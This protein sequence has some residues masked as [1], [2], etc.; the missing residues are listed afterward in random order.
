MPGGFKTFARR[1]VFAAN[2]AIAIAFL[3]ACVAPY[4]NPV[5][6]WFVS[7]L[8]LLF[9]LLFIVLLFSF[10]FW[11]FFRRKYALIIFV[12]LLFGLK[13]LFVSFGFH[14]P[15]KFNYEKKKD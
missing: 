6:W 8:G 7:W 12:V 10:F 11:L 3:L 9:P 14:F 2:F 15:H 13:N 1:F 5:R 4:L